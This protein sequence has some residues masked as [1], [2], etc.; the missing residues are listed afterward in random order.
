MSPLHTVTQ[1]HIFSPMNR[2]CA[3]RLAD[4]SEQQLS[5][6]DVVTELMLVI[7]CA[8]A[9]LLAVL[10]LHALVSEFNGNLRFTLPTFFLTYPVS[11]C[12][13]LLGVPGLKTR[14]PSDVY[15]ML[16]VCG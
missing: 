14:C 1:P 5:N 3:V 6:A 13:R 7:M 15:L 16:T 11:H 9:F 2:I 8:V 10:T 4:L 12:T